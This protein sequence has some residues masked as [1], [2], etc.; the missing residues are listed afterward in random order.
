M[1]DERQIVQTLIRCQVSDLHC[2]PFQ[3]LSIHRNH[4]IS[5]VLIQIWIYT[6]NGC[7]ANPK[8]YYNQ[9]NTFATMYSA[10]SGLSNVS[11]WAISTKEILEYDKLIILTPVLITLC[12]SRIIS[13]YVSSLWNLDPY[14][15]STW[16]NFGKFPVLTATKYKTK[17]ILAPY[18]SGPSCSKRR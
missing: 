3:L 14:W 4:I 18:T 7:F 6:V 10:S 2:L 15:D 9:K 16:L 11:F 1:L 13:V 8:W 5:G 17:T 12:L